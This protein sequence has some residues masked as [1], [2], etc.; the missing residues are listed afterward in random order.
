MK[1]LLATAGACALLTLATVDAADMKSTDT[2]AAPANVLLAPWQGPYGGIPPFDKVKVT[3]LQ[4]ALEAAMTQQLAEID[5]AL[6]SWEAEGVRRLAMVQQLLQLADYAIAEQA[7]VA[8]LDK[9]LGK[10]GY[11][12]QAHAAAIAGETRTWAD[13]CA[14]L[15]RRLDKAPVSICSRRRLVTRIF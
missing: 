6:A 9:A 11:D 1:T 2:S 12:G 10:L 3:D 13:V 5:R 15:P 14:R 8:A 7:Q 4:P